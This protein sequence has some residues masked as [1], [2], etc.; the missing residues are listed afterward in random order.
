M[1]YFRTFG[2]WYKSGSTQSPAFSSAMKAG[3]DMFPQRSG[4]NKK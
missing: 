1:Q 4:I 3:F 2:S